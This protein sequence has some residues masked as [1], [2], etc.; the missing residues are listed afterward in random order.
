MTRTIAIIAMI[1]LA[2]LSRI[3][4]HPPNFA[5]ITAMALFGG[6][7]F[8]SR[9]LA[10]LVPLAAMALS[11]ALLEVLT[12]TPG[13]YHGSWLATG[14]GFHSG[15]WVVYATFGVIVGIGML[16]RGRQSIVS[17]ALATLISSVLF[18][19]VTNFAVWVA[20]VTHPATA[21]YQ[22]NLGGLITCYTMA[23][24]FFTWEVAG[25]L[26]FVTIL[27]GGFA[28]AQRFVPALRPSLIFADAHTY[29]KN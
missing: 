19:V 14:S 21:L 11:D 10:F 18:F 26:F 5:P 6:A 29:P 13:L 27:F 17:V 8:A 3:V 20:D 24:P 1:G 22:P 15:W 16:L 4:P 28:L 9:W 12:R 7:Y 2:A 25:N 23:I